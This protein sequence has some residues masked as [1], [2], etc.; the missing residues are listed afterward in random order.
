MSPMTVKLSMARTRERRKTVF[1][2]SRLSH[3]ARAGEYDHRAN[4][5]SISSAMSRSPSVTLSNSDWAV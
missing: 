3:M 4:A 1:E 2:S 5:G